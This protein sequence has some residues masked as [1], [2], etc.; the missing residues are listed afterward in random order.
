MSYCFQRIIGLKSP[1]PSLGLCWILLIWWGFFCFWEAG[2]EIPVNT[3][4]HFF[5][6]VIWEDNVDQIKLMWWCFTEVLGRGDL[7]KKVYFTAQFIGWCPLGMLV[8]KSSKV[9]LVG[10][11]VLYCNNSAMGN[12]RNHSN[13][14]I[15]FKKK[16]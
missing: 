3:S 9:V 11:W 5:T 7:M 12:C 6:S 2:A 13:Y 4:L 16:G 8:A 14:R 15:T 1:S 10:R